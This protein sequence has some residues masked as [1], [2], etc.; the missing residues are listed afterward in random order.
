MDCFIVVIHFKEYGG[1]DL[2]ISRNI[3]HN[4]Q[5]IPSPIDSK[6]PNIFSKKSHCA[7]SKQH[8][9][10]PSNISPRFSQGCRLMADYFNIASFGV[11]NVCRI[12]SRAVLRTKPWWAVGETPCGAAKQSCSFGFHATECHTHRPAS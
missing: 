2:R 8:C 5:K 12:V 3:W 6:P 10:G 4:I 7:S 9:G 11:E 1:H